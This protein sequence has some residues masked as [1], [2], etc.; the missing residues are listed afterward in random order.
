MGIQKIKVAKQTTM[1]KRDL[2]ITHCT[3]QTSV[4]ASFRRRNRN[5]VPG[6]NRL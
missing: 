4:M 2:D 1:A 6:M 5:D 3:K